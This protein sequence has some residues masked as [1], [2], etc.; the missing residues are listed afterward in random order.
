ML[1][2][3]VDKHINYKIISNLYKNIWLIKYNLKENNINMNKN[4]NH[5]HF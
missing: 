4:I 5:Y 3:I 2:K 1:I